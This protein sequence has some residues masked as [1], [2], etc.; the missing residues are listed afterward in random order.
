MA[1]LE[2]IR[3]K[4]GILIVVLIGVALLSFVIDPSTLETTL[5]T[6]SSK[7]DVGKID[8][9]SISYEKFQAKVDYYS[10][11]YSMTTNNTV[12]Q[13]T[14]DAIT[15][16]AWL[17][18]EN[19]LFILPLIESSG[20]TVGEDELFDLSYGSEISEIIKREPAFADASGN[21]SKEQFAQFISAISTDESGR[22]GRYWGFLEE[23]VLRQQYFTKYTSLLSSSS[24]MNS[25]EQ[26]RSIDEN[27]IVSDC[28]FIM[29]PTGFTRDTT[30]KVSSEEIK[31]YYEL[32][33]EE[34]KVEAS[35]DIEFV[36]YEVLPLERDFEEAQIMINREYP[37]FVKTTNLK[38][39]LSRYSD[40]PLQNVYYKKGELASMYP[41]VEE[42]AFESNEKVLPVYLHDESIY[43]AA[44]IADRKML[45]D[46]V[47]VNHILLPISDNDRADS[48]INEI[49]RGRVSFSEVA[50]EHS[51]DTNPN[52]K[53]GEL[54]WM[55]QVQMIP[56]LEEVLATKPNTLTKIV[57]DYGLHIIKVTE[58]TK[59]QEKVQIALLTKEVTASEQTYQHFYA[60]ANN[61]ASGSNGNIST[62][63]N[64][65]DQ[66]N[67]PVVPV[68]A[69]A[70]GARKVSR[71]DDAKEISRWVYEA[72]KGDVSPII[73][74]DNK[75][76]FVVALKNI[77][78]KG[79]AP[80][81]KVSTEIEFKLLA[82]K[83][84][85]KLL[86]E[87]KTKV[88]G[89]TTLEEMAEALN[90]TVSTRN[91]VSFGAYSSGN[92][93][94]V[95]VGTISGLEPGVISEP[96][97]G[98]VGVYIAR[99]NKKNTQAYFTED[100]AKARNKQVSGYQ[101]GQLMN[102]FKEMANE[103]DNRARFY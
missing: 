38:S 45:P 67:L 33:K 89:L 68:N 76:F 2:K 39:Y 64:I 65:V 56:G 63:N 49:N 41:E 98:N 75:Y 87:V 69:L 59:L 57:S 40:T 16:S 28:E 70:E 43:I 95:L 97:A 101:I 84:V 50:K 37:E 27:N 34:Y 23:N 6:F 10:D 62:F 91:G 14:L 99:V 77:T 20:I 3:V 25:I 48:L 11:I 42:F 100:D 18:F 82:Q 52:V 31:K 102:T 103:E 7:Y 61:L 5:R 92:F 24:V 44:R 88:A 1:V 79:Y 83:R 78:E 35:R 86:A 26:L 80:L 51:L 90:T 21:F 60:Q 8:G 71:Y 94:P 19:R 32:H 36:A 81:S 66:E 12:S 29:V 17:D 74:L 72:K 46:S 73:T 9:K 22:L 96:F 58:R 54:G 47:F 55:T 30:L 15:Q 4:F 53:P 93:E 13:E 85:E